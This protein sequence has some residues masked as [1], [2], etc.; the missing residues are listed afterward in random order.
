MLQI[1]KV[2]IE[3]NEVFDKLIP[4]YDTNHGKMVNARELHFA[5]GIKKKF[6]D[7]IKFYTKDY[8]G[9]SYGTTTIQPEHPEEFDYFSYE[10]PATQGIGKKI[11]YLLSIDIGKEIAMMTRSIMG[12]EVRKYFIEAE[13]TLVKMQKVLVNPEKTPE[14][15][16]A[17][18]L[19]LSQE[20][21]AQKE[22]EIKK[23]I[24]NKEYNKRVNMNLRKEIKELK[25]NNAGIDIDKI[26]SDKEEK[27]EYLEGSVERL[28]DQNAQLKARLNHL[29]A[30]KLDGK[31]ILNAFA[32]VDVARRQRFVLNNNAK[33]QAKVKAYVFRK[34]AILN[35]GIIL[36][37]NPSKSLVDNIN[38]EDM[39][40]AII[41][42]IE[43]LQKTINNTE[44]FDE[45]FEIQM[46]RANEFLGKIEFENNCIEESIEEDMKV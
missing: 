8:S 17:E 5:L 16:I 34:D 44:T 36:N 1:E 42:Y 32:K 33:E 3:S 22:I 25:K 31:S 26:L 13:K 46:K 4:I 2:K 39:D 7:W 6:S 45:L 10:V 12:K 18:A 23:A 21:L 28:E 15:K 40:K 30:I 43:A 29:I 11:E 9:Y 19:L 41:A 37:D 14:Q 35:A 38:V 20:I 24:R 27:I